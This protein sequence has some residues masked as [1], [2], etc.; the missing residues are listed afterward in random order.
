[1]SICNGYILLGYSLYWRALSAWA[2]IHIST[3]F[4]TG[5]HVNV[6]NCFIQ[7]LNCTAN[8]QLSGW[9]MCTLYLSVD[10]MTLYHVAR[11]PSWSPKCLSI[12]WFYFREKWGHDIDVCLKSRNLHFSMSIYF[13]DKKCFGNVFGEFLNILIVL[14]MQ[15]ETNLIWICVFNSFND[16]W[17]F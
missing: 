2:N 14:T 17:G 10:F 13:D 3:Q 11:V 4:Y 5:C 15:Q 6:N 16:L 8:N 12:R 1:M 9:C 7:V